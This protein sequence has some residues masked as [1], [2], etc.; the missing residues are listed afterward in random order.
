MKT[1][2]AIILSVTKEVP[3]VANINKL[4]NN[5][6]RC[7]MPWGREARQCQHT[8]RHLELTTHI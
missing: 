7:C 2:A 4:L 8:G 1:N 3:S 6:G 5:R